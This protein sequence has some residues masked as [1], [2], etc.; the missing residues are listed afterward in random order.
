MRLAPSPRVEPPSVEPAPSQEDPTYV[1]A[2]VAQAAEGALAEAK[3]GERAAAEALLVQDAPAQVGEAAQAGGEGGGE[4]LAARQSTGQRLEE[5][6]AEIRSVKENLKALQ[7][8][9]RAV[10][11]A[12]D[13]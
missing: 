1:P 10:S 2:D 4:G 5:I 12:T 7:D 11:Q 9:I 3:E 8:E 6:Q 13:V